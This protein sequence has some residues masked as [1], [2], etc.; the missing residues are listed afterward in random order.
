ME[1]P[2]LKFDLASR[3][4]FVQRMAATAFGL[5]ILTTGRSLAEDA[6][7]IPTNGPGFGSAKRVIVLQ[8]NGGMSHIDTFDPKKGNGPGRPINTSADFQVTEYL[9]ETAKLAN[10][11]CVLRSMTAEVGVHGPAKYVMRTGYAGRGTVLHPNIGAWAQ[12]Y[13]GRS[14][15]QIPSTACINRRSDRGN[16]FFSS[17]HAPLAIGEPNAGIGNIEALTGDHLMLRRTQL[18]NALDSDFRKRYPDKQVHAYNGFYDDAVALMKSSELDAFDLKQESVSVRE[19]YGSSRFGQGCL[20]ARRLVQSGV[21]FVEVAHEGWDMHKNL[22]DDIVELTP[23]FDQAF[24]A[25]LRDLESQGMLDDTLVVVSTEFGRK[26]KFDGNGRGHHPVCFS[27]VLAGAGVKQGYVHG[28]S[29]DDGGYVDEDE[30]TIGNFHATIGWAMGLPLST[31]AVSPSGRPF[32]VGDK[33][34]PVMNVFA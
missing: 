13:L 32:T 4:Q 11:L 33:Q 25:L 19:S 3:R 15:A 28:A 29:D 9:P 6:D 10:R 26:P 7:V 5:N 20:L 14:H 31:E 23:V 8:L 21:R 34:K 2:L 16:G 22:E 12:H 17:S 18:L 27:T 1:D 30:V 24:T